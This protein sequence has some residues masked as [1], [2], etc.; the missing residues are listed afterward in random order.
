MAY[1][2]FQDGTQ[3]FG[4]PD[5]PVTVNSVTYIAEDI[6]M[7]TPTTVVE[8]RDTNG[9][10]TGQVIIPQTINGTAKLQLATSSTVMPPI[11]QT[12]SI[13]GATMY[14]TEVGAA[15]TQGAYVYANITF[16]RKIN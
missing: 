4:I 7:T 14:V 5:S 13:Q 8:I 6:N 10:P 1:T 11:G 16:R 15:Y 3:A 12:F 2:P 9:I